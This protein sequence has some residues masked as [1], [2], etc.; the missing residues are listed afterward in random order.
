MKFLTYN[1]LKLTIET[2]NLLEIVNNDWRLIDEAENIALEQIKEWLRKICD[3][4]FELRTI[5]EFK[6]NV[7]Y[8]NEDR[9]K[10]N[11]NSENKAFEELYNMILIDNEFTL[12]CDA[13]E[14]L[15]KK[16]NTCADKT[17]EK[18]IPSFYPGDHQFTPTPDPNYNESCGLITCANGV[19]ASNDILNYFNTIYTTDAGTAGTAGY[20]IS[21]V[22]YNQLTV[23][24]AT[25]I[26]NNI[27]YF[28]Q[29]LQVNKDRD[30]SKDDRNHTLIQLTIDILKFILFQRVAVR[31]MPQLVIDRYNMA[32][33]RLRMAATGKT[34]MKLRPIKYSEAFQENMPLR[35]GYSNVNRRFDY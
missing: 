3:I 2:D 19:L 35:F 7:L 13:E 27:N 29:Y 31:Q 28:D 30:W 22:N 1:D 17:Y 23:L 32:I 5:K 26:Y 25:M 16:W 10:V 34:E 9:I 11:Y 24:Q 8:A 18:P 14:I 20:S 21:T 6:V 15:V 33:D 12:I 4:D